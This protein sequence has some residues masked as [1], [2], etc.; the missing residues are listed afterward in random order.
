[1]IENVGPRT[2]SDAAEQRGVRRRYEAF[3]KIAAE[4]P[5]CSGPGCQRDVYAMDVALSGDGG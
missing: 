4:Y 1:M 5:G 3:R 2:R